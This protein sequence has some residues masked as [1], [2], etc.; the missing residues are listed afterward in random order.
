MERARVGAVRYRQP[1]QQTAEA[2]C[3][4]TGKELA[5]FSIF[6]SI[7]GEEMVGFTNITGEEMVREK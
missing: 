3:I 2:V 4:L 1:L 7:I 5:P 6:S